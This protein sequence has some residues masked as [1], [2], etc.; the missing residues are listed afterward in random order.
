MKREYHIFVLASALLLCAVP[1]AFAQEPN[2]DKLANVPFNENYPTKETTQTLRDE[3]LFQRATQVYLWALPILNTMGMKEGSEKVFGAGYNV[4]PTWK[5]RLDAKTIV[6]TPNSDVIYA[7]SYLDVGKDGPLVVEVPGLIQ[8]MFDD[9]YQRPLQ[10]VAPGGTPW[11]GDVGFFGPDKGKG[12]KFLLL[13]PGYS[14]PIPSDTFVYRSATNNIFLFWRAFYKDASDLGPPD[15]L[16]AET[17]VYPLGKEDSAKPMEFPDASAKPANMIWPQDASAF[18]V[19]KR[20][21]DS[22]PVNAVPDADW[23][24][25]LAALGIVKGKPF[26]PNPHTREI[27]DKAAKTAWKMSKVIAYEDTQ[28]WAGAHVFP[29]RQWLDPNLDMALDLTWMR[30]ADNYRDLD[31]RIAFF[32]CYYSIS[33]GMIS[34]VPGLGAR[35]MV[36]FKDADG[37]PL[38]GGKHYRLNLP[39][40]IPAERFWS[41]TLY[42]AEQASGLANGQPF[43][44]LGSRD[45]PVANADGSVDIYLAPAAPKGQEKNWMRTVPGKGYFTIIRLYGPTEAAFSGW[46]WFDKN[47]KPGDIEK[48]K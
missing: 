27:L 12:G 38:L 19:L 3:L 2:F 39:K 26:N 43:P 32:T 42:D 31:A 14:G 4:L 33:P 30:T 28:T 22:E 8:G 5:Q 13:P 29:D 24:G 6:T 21:I 7:M 20:F 34:R 10:G 17:K 41:L 18:E 44:S 35:Y 25:M 16:I 1:V 23:R 11:S 45:N 40:G 46:P 36:A 9:F 48:A 37:D 47:W 15:K